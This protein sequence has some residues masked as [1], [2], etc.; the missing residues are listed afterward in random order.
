M[1]DNIR[2][3]SI[4]L[5][6]IKSPFSPYKKNSKRF[7]GGGY[8]PFGPLKIEAVQKWPPMTAYNPYFLLPNPIQ[9]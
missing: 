8:P 5:G 6:V 9:L 2:K 7:F 4:E 3:T 1:E